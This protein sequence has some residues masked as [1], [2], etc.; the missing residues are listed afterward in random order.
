MN[1]T[2]KCL[3][4]ECGFKGSYLTSLTM[5]YAVTQTLQTWEPCMKIK[6]WLLDCN[7]R[8]KKW[9]RDTARSQPSPLNLQLVLGVITISLQ[10]LHS[11]LCRIISWIIL[12]VSPGLPADALITPILQCNSSILFSL[13]YIMNLGKSVLCFPAS[14]IFWIIES[15][16]HHS[17][18]M[19]SLL[20]S[21]VKAHL[22]TL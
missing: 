8:P 6:L 2:I 11:T 5:Q 21:H 14:F 22:F 12:V 18:C 20:C 4:C 19:F 17:T 10:L 13:Q 7:T 3:F 16:H 9:G 15:I 1:T